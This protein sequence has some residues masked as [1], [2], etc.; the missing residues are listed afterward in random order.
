MVRV[1]V[2]DDH[3]LLREGVAAVL[4]GNADLRIVGEAGDGHEAIEK[5]RALQPDVTVMDLQMPLMSGIDAI[6]AIRREAPQAR[7]VVLATLAGD[8]L[9]TR[10]L[11]AGAYGYVLK[12][13]VRADLPDIIRAVHSGMKRIEP[14][15]ALQ[16]ADF[17]SDPTVTSRE[18][19]VLQLIS[20]GNSNKL[21]ART[22][23]ISE[24]TVKSH[25]KNIISKLDA[26]DRT[27]AMTLAVR[28]GIIQL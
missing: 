19:Q 13:R 4:T 23:T 10:A 11:K 26:R 21:I 14:A 22:L 20:S 17:A 24:E 28:R 3:P 9:A 16:I 1:L 6:H 27:H 7:V 15:I 8:V 5:F 25:V 12:E 18:I 2:V